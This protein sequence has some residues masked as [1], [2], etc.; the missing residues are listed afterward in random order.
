MNITRGRA[1]DPSSM[2]RR[3]FLAGAA[4]AL[5]AGAWLLTS[6]AAGAQSAT[7]GIDPAKWSPEYVTS[8]AGTDEVDTAAECAKVVPLD[9]KGRL[10]YWWIGPNRGRRPR[11]TTRSTTSSGRPSKATYPNIETDDS[12]TSTTTT[13]STSCAPRRSATPR[14]WSPS[15]RSSGASSSP[16]RASFEELEARG[17]R[18]RDRRLLARR[19]EVGDLRRQD[20]RHP[21]QQRDHGVHLERRASSRRPGSIP[22]TRRRPGTTSSPTPSRSRTRPARP[23]TAWSPSRTPATRRSASCR[24]SG[25]MAAARSTRP[26]RRP[27]YEKVWINNDGAKAALQASYDMYVRDKSVPTSALTNTQTENQAP[28]HRRPAGDDDRPPGRVRQDGRPRRQGDRRRQ[29]GGRRR[30]SPTCATA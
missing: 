27:T 4:T 28:V 17:R 20:L 22:R 16:P 13:C 23:A 25:P 18:L 24:S 2:G 5:T 3:Q 11:S 9:Y 19:D 29:G 10:S 30:W 26:S 12:R 1:S 8:I 6:A 21:D 15:C 14:R 7:M